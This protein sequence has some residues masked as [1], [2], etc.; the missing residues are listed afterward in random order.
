MTDEIPSLQ[1]MFDRAYVGLYEQGFEQSLNH[2][3][4]CLYNAP[5]GK[6]CAWGH[7]DPTL[8]LDA[9]GLAI[10]PN[11]SDDGIM[12][13]GLAGNLDDHALEFAARLQSA[14]DRIESRRPARMRRALEALANQHRLLVPVIL[15]EP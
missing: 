6:H 3:G 14:H 4:G 9:E 5:D 7:V 2:A 8:P 13:Y 1:E 10:A 12:R 15:E 11:C